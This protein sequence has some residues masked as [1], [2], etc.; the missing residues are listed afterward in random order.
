MPPSAHLAEAEYRAALA[1]RRRLSA[2]QPDESGYF[3][4]VA[5]Q[6]QALGDIAAGA[7]ERARACGYYREAVEQFDQ[8]DRRW[9]MTD[10]DRN[11]TYARAR[12]A[13]R[14]CA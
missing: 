12:T 8:L 10:F 5:I 4:D 9:G 14:S 7:G 11:D 6:L 13:L 3:R 2:Q 1:I